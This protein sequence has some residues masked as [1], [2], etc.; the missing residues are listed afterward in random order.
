[1]RRLLNGNK[2]NEIEEKKRQKNWDEEY[3]KNIYKSKPGTILDFF[4]LDKQSRGYNWGI[5]RQRKTDLTN[6]QDIM[7][8]GCDNKIGFYQTQ[9]RSRSKGN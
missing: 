8:L 2:Q 7:N 4:F 3:I 1:M 5:M 6:I 9:T